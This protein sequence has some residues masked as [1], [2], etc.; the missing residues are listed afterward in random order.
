MLYTAGAM[1][2]KYVMKMIKIFH[3]I[4]TLD[5]GGAE[6]F[7]SRL[8][9]RADKGRFENIVV[10]MTNIG[11]VGE[12][13][14]SAGIQVFSLGMKKGLPDPVGMIR[15]IKQVRKF[16][17]DI[18]QCWMYHSN[19]LGV[20]IKLFFPK[21][22]II[23]NIR[24]S[25]ME[26]GA[27][28][29]IYDLT[30][31]AGAF[32]SRMPDFLIFNSFAGK[33]FHFELGYWNSKWAIFHNGI[34]PEKYRPLLRKDHFLRAELDI[35]EKS[36]VITCVAR[37]DPMKDHKT[38][39]DAV[40]I[41][42]ENKSDVH[43]IMA[44]RGM[45]PENK[46]IQEQIKE[47]EK[48]EHIHLIGERAD[49][50]RLYSISDLACSSSAYGEGFSNAIAEAMAAS[51]PCVVTDTGDSAFIV[52]NTGAV[53]PVRDSTALAREW[54]KMMETDGISFLEYGKQAEKRIH[55]KFRLAHTI[56]RY[57]SLFSE[58]VS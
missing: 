54:K 24:C 18:I 16:Q 29:I 30:V 25:N 12:K 35:P 6:L 49:I 13:I 47:I 27:Y 57:E 45:I 37:F 50:N 2:S 19:L 20:F 58:L 11:N 41:I 22:K 1:Q 48:K 38:F 9:A 52:G 15:L 14:A 36:F 10:S 31:K 7:L 17:P 56:T 46:I 34:D 33:R 23:W 21:I 55:T 5:T 4:S 40:K 3:L 28:G 8:V 26:F 42:L 53:V 32:L 51:V 43:F 39:F 44:G